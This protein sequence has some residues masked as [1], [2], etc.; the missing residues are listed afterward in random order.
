VYL[1]FLNAAARVPDEI[2]PGLSSDGCSPTHRARAVAKITQ[3]AANRSN[4]RFAVRVLRSDHQGP[5]LARPSE[6]NLSAHV[7]A[8]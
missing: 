5:A 7:R 3:G 6:K 8:A 1:A 2:V 4:R